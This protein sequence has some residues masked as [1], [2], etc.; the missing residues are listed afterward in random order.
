[1]TYSAIHALADNLRRLM[2][3]GELT[4]QQLAARTGVSQKA[5]S[6]L[7]N[8]GGTS[9]KEPRLGTIEKLADGLGIPAWQLQIPN[10]PIELLR[11]HTL[12]KVVENFRDA[13][14]VGREN[15]CR[16]AESEVR[17]TAVTG[18]IHDQP[19]RTAEQ[20]NGRRA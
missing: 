12:S 13:G 2:E 16:V 1:M 17:Y 4:Q 5:I 20:R 7:L 3:D 8:Y 14:A 18:T 11:N 9:S 19:T 10:L 15:I 6:D